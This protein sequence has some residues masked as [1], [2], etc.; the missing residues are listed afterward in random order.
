MTKHHPLRRVAFVSLTVFLLLGAQSAVAARSAK[1]AGDDKAATDA[2]VSGDRSAQRNARIAS[3]LKRVD[4]DGD[5]MVSQAEAD[6]FVTTRFDRLDTKHK[7][8]L[9]LEDYEASLTRGIDRAA[10]RG[11][12]ARKARLEAVLPRLEAEFKAMNKAGDGHLTKEEFLAD[13]HARFAASDTDKDG[14]LSLAEMQNAPG[15]SF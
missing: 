6:S 15:H 9:T 3:F 14:K 2:T 5:G 1:P 10:E 13:S 8:Y 7:G 4:K 11:D 12:D